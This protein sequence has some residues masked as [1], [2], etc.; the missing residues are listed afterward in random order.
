MERCV[1]NL[2]NGQ[3]VIQSLQLLLQI[4]KQ[5]PQSSKCWF[6]GSNSE[7]MWGIIENFEQEYH[8]LDLILNDLS[9]YKCKFI[10]H[11]SKI[12]RNMSKN[13]ISRLTI[14]PNGVGHLKEIQ[15]R[16]KFLDFVL[17]NSSL[18]LSKVQLSLIYDILIDNS[19]STDESDLCFS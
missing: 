8:L 13:E 18:S 9:R 2:S 7:T 5:Y 14:Q 3:S 10:S 16:Q 15:I 17:A 1:I 6:S 4:I 11:I 12:K 19:L